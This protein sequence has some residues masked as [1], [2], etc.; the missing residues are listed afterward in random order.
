MNKL[1]LTILLAILFLTGCTTAL[2]Q[3]SMIQRVVKRQKLANGSIILYGY[4]AP[5][6]KNQ[7]KELA[8]I[9]HAWGVERFKGMTNISGG[10][11]LLL[12]QGTNYLNKNEKMPANYMYLF[13]PNQ[14]E[15]FGINYDAMADAYVTF[16][17][18]KN[19]PAYHNSPF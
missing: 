10:Y 14:H 7:C 12:E 5:N 8:K 18:C 9:S 6:G 16:Y 11:G 3:N 19:P 4:R 13:I 17:Q 2:N 1:S 15:L